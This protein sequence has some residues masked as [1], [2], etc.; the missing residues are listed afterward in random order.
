MDERFALRAKGGEKGNASFG[1][2]IEVD[3]VRIQ[4]NAAFDET[5][6]ADIRS[7]SS[8]NIESVEV[9]TGIPSVEHGDLSSGL[10]KI[11]TRKGKTPLTV[12]LSTSPG[13]KQ[14]AV[15]KGFSLG[16]DAGTLNT[17]F[18]HTKSVSDPALPYTSYA[19]NAIAVKYSHTLNK[20][21]GMPLSFDLGL[22]GNI[23]GYD[24]KADPDAFRETYTYMQDNSLRANA[25]ARW[26]LSKAWITN[27]EFSGSVSYSDRLSKLNTNRSSLSSQASFHS[28]EQ[29]YFIATNYD[30]DPDAPPGLRVAISLDIQANFTEGCIEV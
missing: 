28:L 1:T 11:H 17:S 18:E 15:S 27:L 6:G 20:S 3:G 8:T 24:S 29:G 23:G 14:A 30:E 22:T 19:R 16:K 5:K 7:I 2:A 4:N 21:R 10:V 12:E 9:V 13:N 25:N 26:L